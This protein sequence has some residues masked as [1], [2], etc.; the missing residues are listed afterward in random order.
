MTVW[1]AGNDGG[2][3]SESLTNPPGQD[4]TGSIISDGVVRRPRRRAPA[5]ARSWSS[6][7]A[8]SPATPTYP[9]ISAPGDTITSSCRPYLP[10][11]SDRAQHRQQQQLQHHQRYVDGGAAHRRHR[12]P[13]V[14][15]SPNATPAQIEDAL[16]STAHQYSFGA[17]YENAGGYSTSFDKGTGLVDVVAAANAL[18]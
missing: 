12:G 17:P 13:A 10:I 7:R 6:P 2:D 1:A 3:G 8:A 5:T 15:G 4:P 18:G 9:D 11:C 16:K 14:R